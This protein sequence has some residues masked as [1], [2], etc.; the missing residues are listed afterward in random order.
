[1]KFIIIFFAL[2]FTSLFINIKTTSIAVFLAYKQDEDKKDTIKTLIIML[3]GVIFWS[4]YLT[5]YLD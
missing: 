4:I 5:F 1:M 2:L 3:L